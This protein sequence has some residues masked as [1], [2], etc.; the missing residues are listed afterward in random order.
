MVTEN[1]NFAFWNFLEFG[2]GS[3]FDWRLDDSMDAVHTKLEDQLYITNIYFQ[4]DI[5]LCCFSLW[6]QQA[7][8]FFFPFT[9]DEQL[10]LCQAVI[11]NSSQPQG[12]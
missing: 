9:V 4:E 12:L 1:P 11:S 3:S 8:I 6:T 7:F 10:V 2:G 5:V